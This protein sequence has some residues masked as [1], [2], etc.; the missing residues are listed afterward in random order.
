MP[1]KKGVPYARSDQLKERHTFSL[2]RKAYDGIKR[3]AA[4]LGLSMSAILEGLGRG[5]LFITRV[6]ATFDDLMMAWDLE[7]LAETA[8]IPAERLQEILEGK[9][10]RIQPHELIALESSTGVAYERLD[11]L[12]DKGERQS[13]GC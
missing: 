5:E 1:R 9:G 6:P 7:E 12:A 2:T 8:G 11:Q 3:F 10:D 4:R 13:N